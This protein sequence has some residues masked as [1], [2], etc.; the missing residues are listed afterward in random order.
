MSE[1][2]HEGEEGLNQLLDA[3]ELAGALESEHFK[4]FLDHIPIAIAVSELHLP[5]GPAENIVYVNMEFERLTG[6]VA[7]AVEGRSW[8]FLRGEASGDADNRQLSQAIAD[9][10]DYIGAFVIENG[11]EVRK[12]DAWSNIIEDETGTPVFRLIALADADRRAEK[13]V[14]GLEQRLRDQ[15]L[16]L[17]ELQHRVKNN[18]QMITA[19]IRLEARNMPPDEANQKGFDRLAGRVEA[20]ALLYRFLS[21][22]DQEQ[23]VDLGVYLSEIASAV[24][25]AH[26]V[27][28]IHLDLQVDTWPV[29]INVAMPAG[30]LV[31]ELLTNAL[32]YAFDGRSGGTITLHSLVDTYGCHVMVSDDGVGLAPGVRWPEAGK[33]SAMIVRS[34]RENAKARV[35]VESMS[36][37]GMCVTV[38]F[39]R[40]DATKP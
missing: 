24:M 37:K 16:L 19:L 40:A 15:D 14:D 6:Q 3:A 8:D 30:L 12:V 9:E 11:D 21:A 33:L 17:R 7:A 32:K 18:L 25:H 4:Q 20:L 38:F 2:D 13:Q 23:A 28:G 26:A 29:S 1:S 27:E 10:Q 22:E 5:D 31:N 36:G 35:D 39:A 34:L